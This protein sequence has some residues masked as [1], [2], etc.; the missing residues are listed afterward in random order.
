MS[1]LP[2]SQS[3][4]DA[5][6]TVSAR[7]G[8]VRT[9]AGGRVGAIVFW[10][11]A[12][13][14]L[15]GNLGARGLWKSEARWGEVSR[16]MM[17]SGDY[18]HPTINGGPYF[19]KPLLGYWLIVGAA[20]V[21]GRLDEFVVRLPGAVCGLIALGATISLGR[22]LWSEAAGRAAGWLLLT[23]YGFLFFARQGM[24]DVEQLAATTAAIAWYWA[25]RDRRT[26]WTY[27]VFYLICAAGAQ[28]KG[29]AS[30]VVPALAVFAD[31][32]RGGRWR[33]HLKWEHAWALVIGLMVFAEPLAFADLHAPKGYGQSGLLM[34][35]RENFTRYSDAFDHKG[36][37]HTYFWGV[38][39]LFM[40][41]SPLLIVG[42][43]DSVRRWRTLDEATRWGLTAFAIIFLF[44]TL[45]GSRRD[46]YILPILPLCAWLAAGYLFAPADE[47]AR[48]LTV[49]FE[50]WLMIV[51]AALLVI[52]PL[53]WPVA[54]KLTRFEAPSELVWVTPVIGLVGLLPFVLT[55]W[56][57]AAMGGMSAGV[58][59]AAV[60]MGGFFCLQYPIVDCFSPEK[61]F[62]LALRERLGA[63]PEGSYSLAI[64]RDWKAAAGALF[65]LDRDEP[66]PR[67]WSEA[68][69]REFFSDVGRRRVLLTYNDYPSYL[70][71]AGLADAIVKQPDLVEATYP[72]ELKQSG[73]LAVYILEPGVPASGVGD[74]RAPS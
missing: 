31:I 7:T 21:L 10:A 46:Y 1:E 4:M 63:M 19:D 11:A 47:K 70:R 55:R 41:W 36:G 43:I 72:W 14:L 32:I 65:Y 15:F 50:N 12:I 13:V 30:F 26:L 66:L 60:L 57:R 51:A 29:L 8:D 17:R 6:A 42:M 40:P 68:M 25:R 61:P 59:S 52:S 64:Y 45:S 20:R 18:L 54:R 34:V 74:R 5:G 3:A 38:P 56:S 35:Y 27:L 24:A 33:S 53:A 58:L 71:D 9:A 48:R 16:E 67:L 44:F 23:C 28:T 69:L 62:S 2:V 73:K 37:W 22:R 39:Y 49:R